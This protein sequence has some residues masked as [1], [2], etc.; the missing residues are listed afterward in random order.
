VRLHDR[1]RGAGGLVGAIGIAAGAVS[2]CGASVISVASV[3][4]VERVRS[5]ETALE[6]ARLAPDVYARAEHE[7][8]LARR[9]HASGDDVAA[10]LHAEHALAAYSHAVVVARIA[11]AAAEG[12][13]A[14]A[15]LDATTVQQQSLEATR[16]KLETEA[17]QLEQRA[18]A[19]RAG[20]PAPPSASSPA[21][22]AA[23]RWTL[24]RSL[25]VEA[26][27]I[28]DAARL[29]FPG[30]DDVARAQ[31]GAVAMAERIDAGRPG[32]PSAGAAPPVPIDDVARI[33]ER[34]VDVLTRARRATLDTLGRADV[35]LSELS[36][37]GRWDPSRDERGVVVTLRDPFHGI[38]LSDATTGKLKELGRIAAA[39]PTFVV[40]VVVHD[41]TTPPS[42][43]K[44]DGD[45]RRGDAAVQALIAGGATPSRVEAELAGTATPVADPDDPRTRSHNEPLD[46]VFVGD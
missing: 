34:C 29:A 4:E 3:D 17:A 5:T 19:V 18:Q 9:S 33:R 35:L 23:V 12:T 26:R 1:W 15:T 16:A 20:L 32:H 7:R 41:A 10:N 27:L 8:D 24:D 45:T 2:A 6:G 22:R 13:D 44:P 38:L 11:R 42:A 28:C 14:Q 40:Q 46:V 37:T 36:T 39:H 43:P 25:V 21:E 30:A 31:T